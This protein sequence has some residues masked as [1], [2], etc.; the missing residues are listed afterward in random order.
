MRGA[1]ETRW[2]LGCGAVS[3][4]LDGRVAG[5]CC[6]TEQGR[7]T[8]GMGLAGSGAQDAAR[9]AVVTLGC[10]SVLGHNV[11]DREAR[12]GGRP[13]RWGSYD[14]R[15]LNRPRPHHPD[16]FGSETSG[17]GPEELED[18]VR[19]ATRSAGSRAARPLGICDTGTG[20]SGRPGAGTPSE[21]G[22]C[23][24]LQ[25]R[26]EGG[27]GA[28]WGAGG[29]V[30]GQVG[31]GDGGRLGARGG[32]CAKEG[33]PAQAG[34]CY[35]G[36]DSRTSQIQLVAQPQSLGSAGDC[37]CEERARQQRLRGSSSVWYW[38]PQEP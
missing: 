15:S 27:S 20:W 29:L 33:A 11:G 9:H 7:M 31:P 4:S 37:D 13:G 30:P 32:Q 21:A 26:T 14:C 34:W 16:T 36:G 22:G 18:R 2:A 25:L 12:G 8:H 3:M 38:I 17:E 28:R 5:A 19:A 10:V 1:Q 23:Q 24:D 6:R 35:G